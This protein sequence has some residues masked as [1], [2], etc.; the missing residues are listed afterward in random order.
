[1]K[2]LLIGASGCFGTEFLKVCKEKKIAILSYK[3]K[4]LDVSNYNQLK[5]KN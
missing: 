4:K 5:K 1:M 3:S 2:I